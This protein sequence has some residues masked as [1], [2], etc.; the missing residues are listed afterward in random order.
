[1]APEKKDE[2][3]HALTN[4]YHADK[5]NKNI[6]KRLQTNAHRQGSIKD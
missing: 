5:T 3:K 2:H 1:M 4:Q 6:A